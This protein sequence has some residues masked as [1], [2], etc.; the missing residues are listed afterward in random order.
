MA[1]YQQCVSHIDS[2]F[3]EVPTIPIS[4]EPIF[5]PHSPV[6]DSHNNTSSELIEL[7]NDDE[8]SHNSTAI[9][10]IKMFVDA[11][12]EQSPV[13]VPDTQTPSTSQLVN[14]YSP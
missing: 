13:N 6:E 14:R 2:D 11:E 8:S 1:D 7:D 4:T 5:P 3:I 12:K 9:E 10:D